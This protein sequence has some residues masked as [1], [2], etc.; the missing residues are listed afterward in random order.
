MSLRAALGVIGGAVGFAFGNP[1]LGWAIGSAVGGAL[2]PE[3]IPGP[4]IGEIP[5]QTAQEGGPRPIVFGISQ[6]LMGNI[7]ALG[8]PEIVRSSQ[9]AG[10]GGPK[11]ESEQV[12]RTYAVGICEGPVTGIRRV[13]RNG[14]LVYDATESPILTTE[15][16]LAFL[17]KARLF[18]GTFEQL[19]SPDLEAVLG[20]GTTPAFRGTAYMVMVDED[21]TEMRGAVPQWVFQVGN[22]GAL[23]YRRDVFYEN[24]TW[25]K[26]DG[27]TNVDVLVVGHGG[28]GSGSGGAPDRG[29]NSGGGGGEVKVVMGVDV[30]EVSS[31]SVIVDSRDTNISSEPRF[32]TKFGDIEAIAGGWHS[33]TTSITDDADANGASGG[34]GSAHVSGLTMPI[35][36]GPGF[37]LLSPPQ[38]TGGAAHY[39]TPEGTGN[40]IA[41]VGGGGGGAGGAGVD[42]E[43]GG[44]GG[45]GKFVGD[46]FGTDIGDEGWFGGGGGGGVSTF[47][48]SFYT[49]PSM[50]GKGG[51]GTGSWGSE[52]N[53]GEINGT[54]GVDGTGGGGG[55][56]FIT[57]GGSYTS[58]LAGGKGIVVVRYVD[59][60]VP[61][62]DYESLNGVITEICKRANVPETLLDLTQTED[63]ECLGITITNTYPVSEAI[64]ALAQIYLFDFIPEDALLKT[65][66]RGG[67]AVA[68]ITEDDLV[69][70]EVEDEDER[71]EDSISVPRVLHLNYHDIAGGLVT[72]KQTSERAG[73]RRSIGE[74]S[75][76]SPVIMTSTQAARAVTINHKVMAE[77]QKGTRRISLSDR[78]IGLNISDVI[79]APVAG[80]NRRLRIERAEILDGYQVYECLHDRQSAYTSNVEG[81]P[82]AEQTPPPS[83]I[84]G[85]TLVMPLDIPLLRDAD[86]T[87]G[88]GMYVAISGISSG[89]HGALVELSRDGGENYLDS[90]TSSIETV[91]GELV[92]P[93]G[94]HPQAIPDETNSCRIRIE[95][96]YHDLSET[97]FNGMLNRI[98][99][100]A[101]GSPE[102][103][104][105]LINFAEA[106]ESPA[107]EWTISNLLRG[108]KG[109]ATREH[110]IGSK[111]VLLTRNTLAF[112]PMSSADIGRE[113]TLR[114]VSSGTSQDS[115][116][117][118]SFTFRGLGQT[119]RRPHGLE[120][121][122]DG[123]DLIASWQG[124]GRLGGAGQ[125]THSQNFTGYRV[126]VKDNS[127]LNSYTTQETAITIDATDF[128]AP[129]YVG[130]GQVN[131]LTGTGPVLWVPSDPGIAIPPGGAPDLEAL[132]Y[133]RAVGTYGSLRNG[134]LMERV[135]A[136]DY[137]V[138]LV[139]NGE[140][141]GIWVLTRYEYGATSD[142]ERLG[143]ANVGQ[144]SRGWVQ[145]PDD[146]NIFFM[147]AVREVPAESSIRR[148]DLRL[149]DKT[150]W[151]GTF[152]THIKEYGHNG[153]PF[154]I[155]GE[156]MQALQNKIEVL[157]RDDL[158]TLETINVG[159]GA[160]LGWRIQET[161]ELWFASTDGDNDG[162]LYHVDRD[163]G[164][165]LASYETR[166]FPFGGAVYNGHAYVFCLNN[167]VGEEVHVGI[168]KYRLSDGA[169]VDS[170]LHPGSAGGGATLMGYKQVWARG[171][172]LATGINVGHRVFDMETETYLENE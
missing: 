117:V 74:N 66:L 9:S 104:W 95:A 40:P 14:V 161:D 44:H 107:N 144:Y 26:P 85:P 81:I 149:V 98:N 138:D 151:Q 156:L 105:E 127:G 32:P 42:G 13:W 163:D 33:H 99:L 27:V 162:R 17:E 167:G 100:A 39:F 172:Y 94:D 77:N 111:F 57:I 63:I 89:W 70:D 2:D 24:G 5:Q 60:D 116:T 123:S 91:I 150:Y 83:S 59:P 38:G 113:I 121:Y 73:E 155:D 114:A 164:S 160:N 90:V 62:A 88:L 115:G 15:Q 10:K 101:V 106:D 92:T 69:D 131:S 72:D 3:T 8:P 136:D 4:K 54:I 22:A 78:F 58:S 64:R 18:T 55:A 30:S 45:P 126:F 37:S 171:R 103:G 12:F 50:G 71:R 139:W 87:L 159:S 7:I 135:F 36:R 82:A 120:V 141:A 29:A 124:V 46:I 137:Y 143:A 48:K 158:S 112:V 133:L 142:N 97:T 20:V 11:V 122:E 68:T 21:L 165:I 146:K 166:R 145:D 56:G 110:P 168:F 109:T 93:L 86:D 51:G 96:P 76:E 16:N 153:E 129:I 49:S 6:P 52:G 61:M 119:E 53:E 128:E 1:A 170:F 102:T 19:P 154:I 79:I 67:S 31:V 108:R 118:V 65:V 132:A 75:I 157:S 125:Y 169:E 134:I 23:T 43:Y 25:V 41:A 147:S 28:R 47:A 35:P 84:V 148:Y 80:V 130:V 34:G 140:N 152:T